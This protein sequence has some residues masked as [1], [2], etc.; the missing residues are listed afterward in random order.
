MTAIFFRD[1][2]DMIGSMYLQW[3][4]ERL[5]SLCEMRWVE[6]HDALLSFVDLFEAVIATLK[7]IKA[8]ANWERSTQ[9]NNL[10]HALLS[11]SFLVS[12]HIAEPILS[13]TV[14]LSRK[15]Q[16]K[17]VDISAA[18]NDIGVVREAIQ[19]GREEA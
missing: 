5:L 1:Q 4:R 11:P 7:E 12:L 15:L 17:D 9:A 2:R 14:P 6:R 8:K 3:Q 16:A 19:K 13:M 18:L 10:F